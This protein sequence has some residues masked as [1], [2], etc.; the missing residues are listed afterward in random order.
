M[1]PIYGLTEDGIKKTGRDRK[2]LPKT[3]IYDPALTLT[4]P[5]KI[6]GPSGM[7]AIAHCVE[8][9]YAMDGNP[10]IS[11]VC[12]GGYPGAGAFAAD[13]GGDARGS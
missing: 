8:G 6:A 10:I 11:H 9:L 4:L 13:S 1:T 12:R 5:P 3:V 7:N 2:V